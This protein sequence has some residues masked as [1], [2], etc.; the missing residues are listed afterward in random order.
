LL[1]PLRQSAATQAPTL[2]GLWPLTGTVGAAAIAAVVTLL[3]KRFD[4]KDA[5]SDAA[6]RAIA[7]ADK[8]VNDFIDQVQ[9]QY[10]ED[11]VEW[12]RD[13]TRLVQTWQRERDALEA[14]QTRTEA[15]VEGLEER[16]RAL[17]RQQAVALDY[18]YRLRSLVPPPAPEWP[19]ELRVDGD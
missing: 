4:R 1:R 18:I 12:D 16:E 9:E 14:R 7:D 8:R 15:R 19:V 10:K 6:Q 3:V 13:R 17:L 11:R 2:S 5:R